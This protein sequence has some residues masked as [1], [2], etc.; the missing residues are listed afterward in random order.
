MKKGKL[1][2]IAVI[3]LAL[4]AAVFAF[5]MAGPRFFAALLLGIAL[6]IVYFQ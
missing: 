4:A 1:W 5:A 2:L 6:V 3:I